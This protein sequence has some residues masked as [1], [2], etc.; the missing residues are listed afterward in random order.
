M[1]SS[2]LTLGQLL[3]FEAVFPN[4]KKLKVENYLSGGS[5]SF[6]LNS[7]AF[8]LAFKNQK[9]KF[10]DNNKFISMFFRKENTEFA[11]HVYS[12]INEYEKKGVIISIINP[13]SSLN[14][15]EQYFSMPELP[16]TQTS[17]EFEVNLFKAYLVLNSEFVKKQSI[18]F[19]SSN[20]S[21]DDLKIPMMFFCMQYPI[22]DKLYYDLNQIWIT[23]TIKSIYLFQFLEVNIKT[24]PLLSKFL[25]YFN[26]TTWQEYLKRLIPLTTASLKNENESH[27]D[28]IVEAGDKFTEG[29]TFIEKLIVQEQD[30]LDP[31]D[32]LTIRS[33]PFYKVEDGV[34]RIIF[35]LFVVEK[36][37]KGVYFLLRD[38]NKTLAPEDKIKDI[39]SFY[40]DEFSEKILCYKVI[41]S[42]FP[43]KCIR[44][45]G[46]DIA[47]KNITGGP[48]YYVRKGKDILLFESKDFLIT[49]ENK[50][51]FDFNIYEKEFG[52]ILDFE[53]LPSGKTKPK[54]ILQLIG[55]IRKILKMQFSFDQEYNSKE[56]VIYPILLTHDHQ[57]DTPGF[58]ELIDF[59]FQDEVRE[60]ANERYFT[61][62]IKPLSVVNIDSLIYN[63]EALSNSI[64]LHQMLKL[65]HENK[66]ME[67]KKKNFKSEEV[68]KIYI[69]EYKQRAMAKLLPFDSF[70]NDYIN[71]NGMRKPPPLI[72]IVAESLFKEDYESRKSIKKEIVE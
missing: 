42:I 53:K 10:A 14:L 55:N 33:K 56:V 18:A 5:R 20:E 60:L 25:T 43:T 7:A 35:Q 61:Y 47:D 69:E 59:W 40:G 67:K 54:A 3:E 63:Q 50:M 58:N 57:Y 28:I 64:T 1:N 31:N 52:R 9:S 51:S 29:C 24:Q 21:D 8:F 13:Y 49:A 34:Y 30:E 26:C 11:K 22:S 41:E 46:K 32:F 12:K 27:T 44:F 71:K 70:L 68:F 48:D 66:K 23:Q 4:E 2:S 17:A 15:F 39:R 62:H 38:I 16:E 6:I 65:Y 37:F 36:I 45:S 72:K 19:P